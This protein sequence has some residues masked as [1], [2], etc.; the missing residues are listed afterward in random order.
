LELEEAL[1][2]LY[3]L[4]A[5]KLPSDVERALVA[6]RKKE[7]PDS[8][9]DRVLGSILENI[10]I[11]RE[12]SVP[13]CQDTGIPVFYVTLPHGEDQGRITRAITVATKTAT[14]TVPLRPNSVE[15]LS[16]K[17]SGD[18]TG[19]GIPEIHFSCWKKDITRFSLL[20]KGAGSENIGQCCKLPDASIGAERD[21][22]GVERCVLNAIVNAQGRGCPPMVVGV[23]IAG[24]RSGA[25]AG[26]WVT[27]TR[28]KNLPPLRSEFWGAQTN[29][30]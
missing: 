3:K 9:A 13:L 2:G 23:A 1:V 15:T 30:G 24:S 18:N 19:T 11:A 26:C 8:N 4:A 25:A 5:T 12:G 16:G 22:N 7:T 29:S 14:K 17:N 21:L 10:K 20:L 28:T 6:A 27:K